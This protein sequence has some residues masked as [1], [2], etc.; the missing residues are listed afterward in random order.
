M[1]SNNK[2]ML[3]W[4]LVLPILWLTSLASADYQHSKSGSWMTMSSEQKAEMD[5]IKTILDKQKA[6]TTL[7]TDEQATLDSWQAK[8]KT[9]SWTLREPKDWS[10]ALMWSWSKFPWKD[11]N[12]SDEIKT[13]LDKQK[14]WTTLTDE[15]TTKLATWQA[16]SNWTWSNKKDKKESTTTTT[17]WLSDAYKAKIDTQLENIFN[18]LSNST[19]S[20]QIT[21][22][23]AYVTKF[24]KVQTTISSNSKYSKTKKATYN[25]ILS[26]ILDELNSKIE[27]LNWTDTTSDDEILD[28]LID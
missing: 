22:L 11:N 19:S 13:I 2:K 28:Y 8:M 3:I 5:A 12:I 14:A 1:F 17:S 21:K 15:E 7:T 6:W 24:E 26:Y 16:L 25:S 27:S 9:W 23:E 4:A 20:E 10:W 18:G